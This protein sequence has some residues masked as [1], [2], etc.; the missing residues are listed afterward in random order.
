MEFWYLLLFFTV[1]L[2]GVLD[3]FAAF[4]LFALLTGLRDAFFLRWNHYTL[5]AIGVSFIIMAGPGGLLPLLLVVLDVR[6]VR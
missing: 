4:Y 2:C 3:N 1:V 5:G 6:H